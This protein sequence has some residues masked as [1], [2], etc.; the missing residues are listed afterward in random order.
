MFPGVVE[1][2]RT[3]GFQVACVTNKPQA[4]TV[5]LL[6]LTGLAQFFDA[7]VGGDATPFIKPH[8]GPLLHACALLGA[9]PLATVLV[10]DSHVDVA[11]ARAAGMP[12]YIVRYGYPG[13]G[14]LD[15]A[16]LIDSFVELPALLQK[17]RGT[18]V[19]HSAPS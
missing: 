8:A 7:V 17:A 15:G 10:G 12:V 2:L 19:P 3:A 14:S 4:A 13:A 9:D 5:T 1:G 18:C 16:T 11:A 6:A